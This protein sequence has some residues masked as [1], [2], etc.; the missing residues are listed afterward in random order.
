M[1]EGNEMQFTKMNGAG[2]DFIILDNLD[3]MIP[4]SRFPEI[5]RILCRRHLSV[6]ADGLMVVEPSRK[7]GDFRMLF[8]NADGSAGEM[9]GNGARCICRYGSEH[10]LAGEVQTIETPSGMVTGWRID[11]R[12]YRIRLTDPSVVR[13]DCPVTAGGRDWPCAYVELGEPGL[14]HAVVPYPGLAERTMDQMRELGRELRWSK[15]FPKGANVDFYDLLAPDH[16]TLLTFERG[17]EDFTY[18][19]GTGTGSV[20]TV[21]TLQGKVSGHNVR[22]RM[23]GGELVIDVERDR[24]RVTDLY[25]TGPPNNVCKPE[26]TDEQLP[27]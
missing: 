24:D 14:P 27:Q 3:S 2:N 1:K 11:R 7:G 9:C 6:G 15:V 10:G 12:S 22:A 21:L 5:A 8:F 17:V 4:H 25:L 18:A 20:V 23:P 16:V 13:L 26:I 19:C